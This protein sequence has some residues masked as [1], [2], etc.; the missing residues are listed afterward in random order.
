MIYVYNGLVL[1]LVSWKKKRLGCGNVGGRI[2]GGWFRG[3]GVGF[4]GSKDAIKIRLILFGATSPT[5]FGWFRGN[6]VCCCKHGFITNPKTYVHEKKKSNHDRPTQTSK[7]K[8][9][10]TFRGIKDS[11]KLTL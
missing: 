6:T 2:G 10:Y 1:Y 5:T 3:R 11:K 7:K 9:H 8:A 4:F